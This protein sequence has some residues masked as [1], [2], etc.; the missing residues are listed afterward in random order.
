MSPIVERLF[1]SLKNV[2]E[3]KKTN[4]MLFDQ[5]AFLLAH[6]EKAEY[7]VKQQYLNVFPNLL[8]QVDDCLSD[9][10]NISRPR[11]GLMAVDYCNREDDLGTIATCLMKLHK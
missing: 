6:Y 7:A 1:A 8:A 11:A 9:L 4:F 3:S 5:A 2:E 10:G